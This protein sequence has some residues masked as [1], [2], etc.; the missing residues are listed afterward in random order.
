MP[1]INYHQS[2]E[3][4]VLKKN[5]L[6]SDIVGQEK[7]RRV[8]NA[9]LHFCFHHRQVGDLNS[10]LH[11]SEEKSRSEREELMDQ[12]HHLSA[13]N[14]STKLDNQS[15]KV[16]LQKKEAYLKIRNT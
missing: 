7:N 9:H 15:L 10:R 3:Q 11:L 8:K 1:I 12:L 5:H 2:L 14:A 6:L 13:E 16:R 4:S